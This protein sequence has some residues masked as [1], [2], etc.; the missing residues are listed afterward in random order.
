MARTEREAADQHEIEW[1]LRRFGGDAYDPEAEAAVQRFG[2]DQP[3]A[4]KGSPGGGRW[5]KPGSGGKSGGG[6]AE[7]DK[8]MPEAQRRRELVKAILDV[9]KDV[10][11]DLTSKQARALIKQIEANAKAFIDGQQA[12]RPAGGGGGKGKSGGGGK[13][14]PAGE[15]KPGG[16]DGGGS[17]SDKDGGGKPGGLEGMVQGLKGLLRGFGK[18]MKP[19]DRAKLERHLK[20]LE[21]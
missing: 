19:G 8:P 3:R 1:L 5:V 11:K 21:G 4:E 14:A 10:F 20:G 18:N 17:G 13:D 16:K 7:D 12:S 2:A 6:K 15:G 9:L